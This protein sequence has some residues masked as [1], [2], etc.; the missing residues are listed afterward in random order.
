MDIFIFRRKEELSMRKLKRIICCLLLLAMLAS[1]APDACAEAA[2]SNA[3]VYYPIDF[4]AAVAKSTV[5]QRVSGGCAIASM[6]TIEAYMHGVT[7]DA[8]KQLVYNAVCTANNDPGNN[9]AYWRNVG[10]KTADI[11]WNTVY[12]NL[13][14][15]YPTIVH[16]PA[17]NGIPQHWSVVAGYAGSLRDLEP[18]KFLIVE[19]YPGSPVQTIAQW[20]G[21]APVDRMAC[22]EN[23]IPI[24][25]LSAGI[26]MAV[27]VPKSVHTVGTS[28]SICGYVV[29]N[30]TLTS[31]RI[32]LIDAATGDAIYDETVHPYAASYLVQYQD[33]NVRFAWLS[34]GEYYYTVSAEDSAGNTKTLVKY[35]I[36]DSQWPVSQP[37]APVY[38]V[39][40]HDSGIDTP[41]TLQFLEDCFTV[42]GEPYIR[43]GYRFLGWSLQRT[44]DNRWFI[45]DFPAWMTEAEMQKS[46]QVAGIFQE[47]T[48]VR[49]DE[50]WL[51]DCG[52]STPGYT[53][54]PQ[55]E[56]ICNGAHTFLDGVCTVCG[57]AVPMPEENSVTR[58][59]GADRY[60][61]SIGTADT[62]KNKLGA[63]K[64][65]SIV[66]ASG[67]GFP[68]AL[69]GSYLAAVKNAPILL[70]RENNI[71]EVKDYIKA[72]LAAGGTVYLLGGIN[73][74]PKAMEAGV[75]GFHVKRL[76]GATRYETNLLI[77]QEAGVEGKDIFVCTGLNFADSLSASA[78]GLP[79]LLV[80][81]GLNPSQTEFLSKVSGNFII[82]GGAAAVNATVETQL[83]SHGS[84]K[85]LAGNN[86]YDTSVLVAKEFFAEPTFAVLAYAQNFPDG[87][88]GGPLAYAL[89]APLILTDSNKPSSAVNYV[90]SLGIKSGYVLGGSGLISDSVVKKVFSMAA[91]DTII[92]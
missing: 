50:T 59:F 32:Q 30:T 3:K 66:V 76:G 11:D 14:A 87:L 43:R 25:S 33:Y 81:D 64:F 91:D 46:G 19:V 63:E 17:A 72:N 42:P 23:G 71:N 89:N 45:P 75:D 60:A 36:V 1:L 67:V 56:S 53:F 5:S 18:D 55:W 69:A 29:S 26:R 88:S 86:R 84:V 7:S 21:S 78:T 10:Y 44:P 82:V 77:L 61:T 90:T 2:A 8:E 35:F 22:R 65:S 4:S 73:A 16:R 12:E 9:Y 51:W 41:L 57:E 52:T 28:H 92:N 79:I 13:E 38:T 37:S 74:V 47:G 83:A 27:N 68:D 6:A 54:F 70:V 24:T 15:G 34:E 39:R 58:I 85:R 49:I 31:V 20:R 48:S 40:F 62:L 80:K